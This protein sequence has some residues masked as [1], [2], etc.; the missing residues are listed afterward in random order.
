[1]LLP[2]GYQKRDLDEFVALLGR[3]HVEV[4][5]D[6]RGTPRSRKPGFSKTRLA[7]ALTAAGIAYHH[8]RDLGVPADQR[9]AFRAGDPATL[10]R[11]RERLTSQARE[12]VDRVTDLARDRSVA[13]LCFERSLDDCHRR[14]VAD[15][16][17]ER[18][19]A[20]RCAPIE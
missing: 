12:A 14:L 3:H 4:L 17:Q 15:A 11:Y 20:I 13:L 1:M 18:D 2:V 7:E 9:R 16:V 19:P 10:E 6:V 5:V 8:E